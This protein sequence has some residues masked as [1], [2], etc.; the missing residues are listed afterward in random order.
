MNVPKLV[1]PCGEVLNLSQVPVPGE[2]VCFDAAQWDDIIKET[3]SAASA[4]AERPDPTL[5]REAINDTLAGFSYNIEKCPNCGRLA[6]PTDD[7]TRYRF[8]KLEADEA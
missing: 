3:T 6:V 4:A 5:L 1:C 8:Y 2:R 7:G